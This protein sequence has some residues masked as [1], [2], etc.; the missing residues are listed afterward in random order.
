MKPE[1]E[2]KGRAAQEHR[3]IESVHMLHDDHWTDHFGRRQPV[4]TMSRNHI[5]HILPGLRANAR[6][7]YNSFNLITMYGRSY[8]LAL[9]RHWLDRTPLVTAMRERMGWPACTAEWELN[10]QLQ[11]W[12]NRTQKAHQHGLLSD[13]EYAAIKRNAAGI[14]WETDAFRVAWIFEKD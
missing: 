10:D 12:V 9:P 4:A 14:D 2:A 7:L 6:Q 3:P 1:I 5:A 11:R 8:T 13:E